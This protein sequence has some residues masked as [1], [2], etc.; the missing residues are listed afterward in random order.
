ML[1][2]NKA[3]AESEKLYREILV[4]EPDHPEARHRLGVVLLRTEQI[5]QAI[6]CLSDAVQQGDP[7]T[8]LLGDLG[9]AQMLAGDLPAAEQT[10]R[11]AVE[12]APDN[13]R[14]VNNLG[15]VVGF[16]GNTEESLALFRRV[17]NES[18]AQSNLAFVLSGLGKLDDAKD[19]YHQALNRDPKLKQAAR[20]LAE[21]HRTFEAANKSNS[22]A[23]RNSKSSRSPLQ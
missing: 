5:D 23:P 19:R 14:I 20:G 12:A 2:R 1:E 9:Y 7:S 17:N 8:G 13:E 11:T 16:Q 21:F 4:S 6:K 3:F 15:M 18:E 10:L 22:P